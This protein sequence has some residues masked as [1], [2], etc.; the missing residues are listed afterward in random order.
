MLPVPI[1]SIVSIAAAF[2]WR[3]I[4]ASA[5]ASVLFIGGCRFGEQRITTQWHSLPLIASVCLPV[6]L[7]ACASNPQ[8]V[9]ASCP[10][11]PSVP[12]ALLKPPP[13]LYLL[14]SQQPQVKAAKD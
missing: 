9:T 1:F 11:F 12:T 8:V 10:P 2:P 7:C 14:P 4:A 3:W 6:F 13:T 5:V